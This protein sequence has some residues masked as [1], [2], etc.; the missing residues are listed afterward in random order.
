MAR[1]RIVWHC[2]MI[3][4]TGAA[5]VTPGKKARRT[6]AVASSSGDATGAQEETESVT[7]LKGGKTPVQSLPAGYIMSM[8]HHVLLG[9][10]L[11]RLGVNTI[12]TAGGPGGLVNPHSFNEMWLPKGLSPLPA[13][14]L[15]LGALI[16]DGQLRCLFPA[17]DSFTVSAAPDD[18]E[19]NSSG[20]VIPG[21]KTW[22]N[23]GLKSVPLASIW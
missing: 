8:P 2:W 20:D 13:Q 1:F 14:R 4:S 12:P 18:Q 16:K 11:E 5:W 15:A 7:V 10:P 6:S 3:V 19:W 23:W 21:M 9:D 22:R 17:I